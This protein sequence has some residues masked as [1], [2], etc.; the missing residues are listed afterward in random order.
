M[1]QKVQEAAFMVPILIPFRTTI[2][3][4]FILLDV[5]L[6]VITN[7][8]DQSN[9]NNNNNYSSNMY[10]VFLLLCQASRRQQNHDLFQIKQSKVCGRQKGSTHTRLVLDVLDHES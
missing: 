2:A 5:N 10:I 7:D 8:P 4:S 6:S 3:I 9:N 1:V